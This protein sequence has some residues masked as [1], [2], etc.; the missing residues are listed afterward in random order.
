MSTAKRSRTSLQR[1]YLPLSAWVFFF[2]PLVGWLP[3]SLSLLSWAI[4]LGTG[5]VSVIG[6]W[7]VGFEIKLRGTGGSFWMTLGFLL[8]FAWACLVVAI[9]L[10]A[11]V[12]RVVPE[13][14]NAIVVG[15]NDFFE[16][17]PEAARRALTPILVL[18]A[19][20]A[21][22]ALV[23]LG[24]LLSSWSEEKH[25]QQSFERAIEE[26]RTTAVIASST[27]LCGLMVSL[28][29]AWPDFWQMLFGT[30]A[31]TG[32]ICVGILL[33]TVVNTLVL[34]MRPDNTV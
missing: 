15:V 6:Y 8:S 24:H 26:T 19:T 14:Q 17:T 9:F 32:G 23:V 4:S 10:T 27:L 22:A 2:L 7:E 12:D 16:S 25:R 21:S 1:F 34:L 5:I 20:V 31:I 28:S 29:G 11:I 30:M 3:D 13:E 33:F 18:A